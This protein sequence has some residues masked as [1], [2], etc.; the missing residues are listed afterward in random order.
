MRSL[1]RYT[2]KSYYI[3][4]MNIYKTEAIVLK[5][6]DLGEQD[7]IV[8]FYSRRYGKIR[9][10][11]KGARGIKSRFACVIQPPSYNSLLIY[12]N[13]KG[14]LDVVSEC[15]AK[16]QFLGIKKDLVRFAYVC[17]LIELIDKLTEQGE[18]Q[19]SLF[20]ILLKSLFLMESIP[21]CSLG[22]LIE[23]FQLKLLNI[24]G[25][26]PYLEGCINCGKKVSSTSYFYF[27]LRLGGLLCQNCKSIDGRRVSLSREAFLLMRRLL[28]LK[29]EEIS[30]EK[31]NKEIVKETEAVLRTYLSYQ[32]QIKMP[33]SCFIHNFKKLELMQTAG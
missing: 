1:L 20:R 29:L 30:G 32:G 26:Q 21:K 6:Y 8:V 22:L 19:S 18:S 16:Y 15:I 25:Y 17:Y 3:Q 14:S 5:D 33:D 23:S 11:A 28:F 9:A 31:I 4:K 7:K 24:L 10:I 2:Y 12:K 13:R 27:S